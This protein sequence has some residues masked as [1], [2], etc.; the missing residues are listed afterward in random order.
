MSC[1]INHFSHGGFIEFDKGSFDNWCVFVTR[2]NG[3]RFAPTDVQYFS[4]LKNLAKIYGARTI[5]NDF[6]VIYN[7][8]GA[9]VDKNVL[10]VISA[11]SRHYEDDSLE[12]EIWL[13]V[14]YAGMVAEENKENA[15][16]KKR[17]KRLGM[18]Q[19][20]IENAEPEDAAVFSKGKKWKELDEIMKA[21]GF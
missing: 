2:A 21:S 15:V 11:L 4:R 13:N 12:M 9:E 14:L 7:R 17:I 20:L 8:T 18:F 1:K 10:A 19:L 6:V 5:Y 16:L 3:D